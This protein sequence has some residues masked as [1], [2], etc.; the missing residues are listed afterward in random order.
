M[1]DGGLQC[2][3]YVISLTVDHL[4]IILANALGIFSPAITLVLFAILA[5]LN[6]QTLDTETAFTTVAILS[7][8]THPANMIMTI[9]PQVIASV[10]D[11]ERIQQY[12]LEPVR[13]DKRILLQETP[14]IDDTAAPT[15]AMCIEKVAV[16]NPSS[17]QLILRDVDFIVNKG[18]TVICSGPVGSGKTALAKAIIGELPTSSGTISVSTRG[19]GFCA[20]SAWLPSATIREAVCGFSKEAEISSSWYEEVIGACC[21]TEDLRVLP[22]GDETLIGSR[23]MNLSGGQRQRVVSHLKPSIYHMC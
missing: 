2:K 6:G 17:S 14:K 1:D 20:Q 7:M 10:A 12:L 8:V 19:I 23:G 13:R 3:R 22:S 4:L 15:V 5:N 21:L 11:F 16:Q 18:S 9:I